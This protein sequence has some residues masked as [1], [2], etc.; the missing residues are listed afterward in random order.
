MR[1]LRPYVP[2]SKIDPERRKMSKDTSVNQGE[3]KKTSFV[4]SAPVL[5]KKERTG[6]V[7]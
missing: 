7:L 3:R 6:A 1:A 2:N 4:H 5:S